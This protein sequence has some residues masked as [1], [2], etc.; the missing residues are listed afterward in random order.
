MKKIFEL[1]LSII[2]CFT[3]GAFGSIFTAPNIPIWYANLNKPFFS[4]PNWLFGPAWTLL[5]ILMGIALYIVWNKGIEKEEVRFAIRVFF[6]QLVLNALWSY[7]FFGLHW[8]LFAY[9][10]LL[11]MWLFIVW[12]IVRFAKVSKAAA[13]L[14]VPY[15]CWVSF[16]SMLNLSVW[17]LNR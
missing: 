8:L 5:Y 2:V 6:M 10:E 7:I 11:I 1:L 12:T 17:W 14:L 15:L 4:P 16:A 13:W 9:I 3:A